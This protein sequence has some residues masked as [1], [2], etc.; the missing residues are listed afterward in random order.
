MTQ[1][2][3][4]EKYK[5]DPNICFI[6]PAEIEPDS[7]LNT[8]ESIETLDSINQHIGNSESIEDILQYVFEA[9]KS[10]FVCDRIG[11]AFLTDNDERVTSYLN[12]TDYEVRV[13]D[14]NYSEDLKGSSLEYILQSGKTRIIKD[15]QLYSHRFPKSYSSQFLLKEGVRSN[16]TCPLLVDNRIVG[17]FFRSSRE[18]DAFQEKHVHTHLALANRLSQ[19]IEKAYR[20]EQ[21]KLAM[22]SYTEML[23]FVSHELKS[24]VAT[25]IMD[26]KMM[27]DGYMGEINDKVTERIQRIVVRGEHLLGMVREYLDLARIEDGELQLRS[28]QELDLVEAVIQPMITMQLTAA[29]ARGMTL[30]FNQPEQA[31]KIHADK[32]LLDIVLT[33]LLSNAIKYGDDNGL[34]TV[35]LTHHDSGIRLAVTNEGP[36]FPKAQIPKLFKKFSRIQTPELMKRKGTGVGL[37]T[38]W[39]IIKL[40]GG[41]IKAE[42]EAGSWARFTIDLPVSIHND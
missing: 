18:P 27:L 25:I 24:P 41:R 22:N 33:N 39:R 26:C 4:P 34:I 38:V 40:H 6:D 13:L 16:M 37:Y 19:V 30:E 36:G 29:E 42:S 8:P 12:V 23:G 2:Q 35:D 7:L 17:L 11:L 14:K 1:L 9:S 28:Y 21:L 32:Q 5:N 20:I 15:L 10:L 31:V 3:I